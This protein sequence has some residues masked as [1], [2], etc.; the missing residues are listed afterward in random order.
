MFDPY[1][2]TKE[3]G[4]G[5]GLSIVH[6]VVKRHNGYIKVFT[7]V[8]KGTVFEIYLPAVKVDDK[9]VDSKVERYDELQKEDF[10][11]GKSVLIVEDE[12]LVAMV[13]KEM[14]QVFGCSVDIVEDGKDAIEKY[15]EKLEKNEKYDIVIMDLTIPGGMSGKDAV[16]EIIKIDSSAKVIVASGY[17]TAPIIS[18][19]ED[20]GFKG[21]LVKPFQIKELQNELTRVLLS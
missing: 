6:S 14:L 21:K 13:A 20:Y 8:G 15:S 2:T 12:E 1:F 4:T 16:K 10:L 18:N 3:T 5:L 19:Y 11:K 9:S 17:S 7:E